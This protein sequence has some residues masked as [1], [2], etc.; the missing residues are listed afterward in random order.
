K[1]LPS[2]IYTAMEHFSRSE[3]IDE[4]MGS[5]NKE[6]YLEL[7]RLSA[8]RCPRDLGTRVKSGEVLYHHEVTNQMIWGGF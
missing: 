4:L 8:D 7:K 2:N 1:K 3:F 5:D 6:K